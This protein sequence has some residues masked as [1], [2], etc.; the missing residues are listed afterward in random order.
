MFSVE[1]FR[2]E[3]DKRGLKI[4]WI[5]L[6]LGVKPETVRCYLRGRREP[7]GPVI[8]LMAQILGLKEEDLRVS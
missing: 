2:T 1:K 7:N 8:K 5:A 6:Q 3:I 4:S